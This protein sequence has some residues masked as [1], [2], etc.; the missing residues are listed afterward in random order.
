MA[1]DNAT[2]SAPASTPTPTK[3][4]IRKVTVGVLAGAI[5]TVTMWALK[6]AKLDLSDIAAPLTTILTFVISYLT[7]PGSHERTVTD[8]SGTKSATISP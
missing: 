5:V 1:A 8:S 7:P 3:T 6:S 2:L 4:P